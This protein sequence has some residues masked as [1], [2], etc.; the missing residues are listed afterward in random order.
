MNLN[1]VKSKATTGDTDPLV[2]YISS[3]PKALRLIPALP[4]P[5]VYPHSRE[6]RK[7]SEAQLYSW[8]HREF[9]AS[10]GYVRPV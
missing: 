5:D 8:L 4:Q 9:G 1:E 7:K 2:E 10:P 6:S 3:M